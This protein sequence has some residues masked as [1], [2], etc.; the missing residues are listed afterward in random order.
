[1][2]LVNLLFA[3]AVVCVVWGVVSAVL[4]A[5]ALE[6]RGVDVNL[7]FLKV[8]IFK[9]LVQY[10]D[11]TLKETGRIGPLFYSYIISM[12]LALVTAVA[13]LLLRAR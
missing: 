7:L 12:N 10:R 13:A 3:L 5:V 6:R 1:M 2:G 8:L 11:I 4:I 9:Y